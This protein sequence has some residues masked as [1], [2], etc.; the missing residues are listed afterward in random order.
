V[1]ASQR[2]RDVTIEASLGRC[3]LQVLAMSLIGT[4]PPPA[5][6]LMSASRQLATYNRSGITTWSQYER[7]QVADAVQR[8][9]MQRGA[10]HDGVEGGFCRNAK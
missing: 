5:F 4:E 2:L 9:K 1:A 10:V 7:G 6:G 8:P 3:L